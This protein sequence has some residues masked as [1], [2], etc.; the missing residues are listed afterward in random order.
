MRRIIVGILAVSLSIATLTGCNTIG[1]E[2]TGM[3]IGGVGGGALGS[4]VTG[5]SATGAV[6]GAVGGAFAGRAIASHS[7]Y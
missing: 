3:L 5:G 7:N 4:A 6:V 1:K 2:N